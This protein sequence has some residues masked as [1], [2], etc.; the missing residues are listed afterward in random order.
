[1]EGFGD[2]FSLD[3]MPPQEPA[4][5]STHGDAAT[6]Q[7]QEATA[8]VAVEEE[9]DDTPAAPGQDRLP[10]TRA[11]RRIRS[12]LLRLHN[13][14]HHEMLWRLQAPLPR[15]RLSEDRAA[16]LMLPVIIHTKRC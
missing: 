7:P 11:S 12:P 2:F 9:E 16:I 8:A 4:A 3:D 15:G 6:P 10:W 13:G 14:E 1:M 5:A